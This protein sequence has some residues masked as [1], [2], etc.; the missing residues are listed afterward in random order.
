MRKV[1]KAIYR[2]APGLLTLIPLFVLWE[3]AGRLEWFFVLPPLSE[4]ASQ[5]WELITSGRIAENAGGTIR[6]LLIGLG[7]SV[8]VGL[9]LGVAMGRSRIMEETFGVYV[10]V[11]MSAPVS[12][13]V[14]ILVLIFGTGRESIVAAVVLFTFFVI[15]VNTYT[16]VREVDAKLIEMARSFGC[17]EWLLIRRIVLPGALPL[18]LTGLRLGIGRSFNGAV[19]GEML[20]SV[21]GLGGL[22]ITFG[23]R[24][25]FAQLDALIIIIVGT[26]VAFMTLFERFERRLLEGRF[27]GA[28]D[29]M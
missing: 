22:L 8:G 11:L 12:A 14:P 29:S 16:G 10:D 6:S 15:V 26:A 25:M 24:F 27:V 23:S 19:F 1:G 20:I 13:I 9:A 17:S 21:V 3:V 4:V 7:I 28:D 5:G 18:M 2:R